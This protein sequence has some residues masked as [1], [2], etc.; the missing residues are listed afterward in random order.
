MQY[1]IHFVHMS[2]SAH[3]LTYCRYINK[4]FTYFIWYTG[5]WHLGVSCKERDDFCHHPLKN[6]FDYYYGV[7]LT[8]LK[9]FSTHSEH[10]VIQGRNKNIYNI[11]WGS[12]LATICALLFS[13]KNLRLPR[14]IFWFLLIFTLL[15]AWYFKSTFFN[16]KNLN[17]LIMRNFEVVEQP[18]TFN[19][20]TQHLFSEGVEF[21]TNRSEDNKPF[22][23]MMSWVQ[24]HTVLYN[25][26]PG[27]RGRSKH[28]EYGDNVEE[29]DWS[30]GQIL[31][32]LEV[33]GFKNNTFVYFSSDNGGHLEELN[34]DGTPGGGYNGIYRGRSIIMFKN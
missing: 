20:L 2:C 13:R 15:F 17:S 8:N 31:K 18:I 1:S 29:M 24:V 25:S 23:L 32:A 21:L 4:I 16:M 30:V 14:S 11:Y 19:N 22:F 26:V 3:Y 9:D 6:G 10:T 7:P 34:A 12:L 27:F 28:G 33:L 5:K